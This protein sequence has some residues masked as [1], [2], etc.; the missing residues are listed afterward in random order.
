MA[1]VPGDSTAKIESP[2]GDQSGPGTPL[3]SRCRPKPVTPVSAYT[4]RKR[5]LGPSLGPGTEGATT[6]R[7]TLRIAFTRSPS[8]G[9]AMCLLFTAAAQAAVVEREIDYKSGDT[10]L[11]GSLDYDDARTGKR[12]AVLV[13]REWSGLN[14]HAR[15]QARR[16]AEA[17][18]VALAL[19]MYGEA[20]QA[21][22]P[23]EALM[24]STEIRTN[25]PVMEARFDAAR[26][27]L[28]SQPNVDP[29]RIAAIGYCFGG[30]VVLQMARAGEDLR[31]VVSAH[32]VLDTTAPPAKPAAVKAEVLVLHGAADPYEQKEQVDALDRE[33]KSAGA[34]YKIIIYPGVKHS[35]TNPAAKEYG[36]KQFDMQGD[37]YNADADQRSWKEIL[38]FL[39]RVTR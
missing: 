31:G 38:A 21:H 23:K 3:S 6:V 15:H 39:E 7:N 16:L 35:F 5:P 1:T 29:T 18:Y 8:A 34:R 20:K 28:R 27:L 36:G 22:H 2:P 25:L 13:V 10:A 17:G 37:E 33:L 30:A 26:E 14:E 11:K 4:S 32:G 9:I 24:L 19:D 12:P